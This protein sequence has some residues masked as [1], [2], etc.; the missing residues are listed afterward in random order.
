MGRTQPPVHLDTYTELTQRTVLITG[1]SSGL[2]LEAARQ[3]LRCGA[4]LV[5]LA[6]R[7]FTKGK[8]ACQALL[9]DPDVQ[10]KNPVAEVKLV[11]VDLESYGSVLAFVN[12]VKTESLNLDFLLLNAGISKLS[13]EYGSSG[14]EKMLQINYLSNALIALELLP[15]LY[16]DSKKSGNSSRLSW[17]RSRRHE[18][19]SLIQK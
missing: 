9:A 15:L 7:S 3:F 10:K 5:V 11:I 18:W 2:G 16:A 12:D 13:F 17:I 6:V 8:A 4:S 14:N 1:G 19:T